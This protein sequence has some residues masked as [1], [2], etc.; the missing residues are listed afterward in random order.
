VARQR[1]SSPLPFISIGSVN[2]YVFLG[3]GGQPAPRNWK[4][5]MFNIWMQKMQFGKRSS[6]PRRSM[7]RL[8]PTPCFQRR[9][10]H[11]WNTDR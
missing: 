8:N 9:W 2:T 4:S 3:L 6:L 5:Y 10:F 11:R 7:S 1:N